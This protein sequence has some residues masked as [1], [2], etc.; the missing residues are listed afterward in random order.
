VYGTP[1]PLAVKGNR[2]PN[3][4]GLYDMCGNAA[5]WATQP[6]PARESRPLCGGKMNDPPDRVRC[7]GRVE[8]NRE[9]PLGGLRLWAEL[10]R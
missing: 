6:D 1:F 9:A 2:R 3:A 4:W 8:E 5:E 10:G 7:A